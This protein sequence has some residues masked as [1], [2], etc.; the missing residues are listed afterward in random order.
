MPRGFRLR[1]YNLLD[2]KHRPR[3]TVC[4][5]TY[6]GI[7][8]RGISI[9]SLKEFQDGGFME[10]EGREKARRRALKAWNVRKPILETNRAEAWQAIASVPLKNIRVR[11]YGEQA[12]FFKYKGVY[13]VKPTILER[14]LIDI[15]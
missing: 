2:V 3:V 4:L 14:E 13:G 15:N 1:Y 9:C 12:D 8:A 6:R 11:G 5:A 7:V 10:E